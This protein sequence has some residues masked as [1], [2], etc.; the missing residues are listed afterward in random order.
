MTELL[1]PSE[2]AKRI[3]MNKETLRLLR[4][5]GEGPPYIQI[6][7]KIILYDAADL[8]AWIESKRRNHGTL[9][10]GENLVREVHGGRSSD[11]GVYRMPQP[12]RGA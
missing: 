3:R 8:E 4:K 9:Q 10:A 7:S 11:P 6:S 12:K 2:A 5:V 1:K